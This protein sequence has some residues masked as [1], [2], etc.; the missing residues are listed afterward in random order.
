MHAPS[1]TQ[2]IASLHPNMHAPSMQYNNTQNKFGAQSQNLASIIRGFKIGVT[3]NAR[4]IHPNFKWQARY[5][6]HIIRNEDSWQTI[7][8]Y[9]LNNPAQWEEDILYTTKHT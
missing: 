8:N 7:S 5:H 9:I 6:D 4:M 3:K 2:N 1:E